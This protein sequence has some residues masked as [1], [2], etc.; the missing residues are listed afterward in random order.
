MSLSVAY[1]AG[2]VDQFPA[3]ETDGYTKRSGLT[4]GGGDLSVTVWHDG[5]EQSGYPV[6]IT[7]DGTSGEYAVTYT[8]SDVGLWLVEVLIDFS[9]DVWAGEHVV[10]RTFTKVDASLSDNAT[11]CRFAVWF[12]D[13]GQPRTDLDQ[14]AA[15]VYE[16]D[17]TEKKDLGIKL[18]AAMSPQGVF[19]FVEPSGDFD[20]H[21]PYMLEVV[22]TKGSFTWTSQTGF[23]KVPDA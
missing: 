17:G 19:E 12:E 21:V 23:V 14:V 10:R 4:V 6:T 20:P 7:E 3:Y 9:K 8:P 1:G 11:N 22:A 15:K 18:A 2:V 13:E 5:V 16:P